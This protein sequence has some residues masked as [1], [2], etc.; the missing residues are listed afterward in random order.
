MCGIAGIIKSDLINDKEVD[1]LKAATKEL[2][3]R[4]NRKTLEPKS[5]KE[6]GVKKQKS[7]ETK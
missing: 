6:I 4:V 1:Q 5:T 2:N 7:E 3:K